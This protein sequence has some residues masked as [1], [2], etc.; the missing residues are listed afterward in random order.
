MISLLRQSGHHRAKGNLHNRSGR[1]KVELELELGGRVKVELELELGGRVK[2]ELE[3]E[4]GGV[5]VGWSGQG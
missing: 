5:G 1:V 2:V 4:L 3:L